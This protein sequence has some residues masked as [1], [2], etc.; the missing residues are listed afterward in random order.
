MRNVMCLRHLLILG[1][2]GSTLVACGLLPF[3]PSNKTHVLGHVYDTL[4]RPVPGARIDVVDGPQAGVSTTADARGGFEFV[5]T[6]SGAVRLRASRD[7][8]EP[9]TIAAEWLPSAS[10]QTIDLTLRTLGPALPLVPGSYTLTVTSD[11]S[12]AT[13][14]YRVPCEGFPADLR[15]RTYEASITPST[16][17][18]FVADLASPTMTKPPGVTCRLSAASP[19]VRGCFAF[20]VAGQFVGFEIQNS[21]GWDWI[22]EWPGFRYL[23]IQGTAPTSEPA[24]ATES[25]ITIPFF[26][27]FEYCQLK[28]A[29]GQPT[30]GQVPAEQVIEYRSCSSEHDTM[31]FTKH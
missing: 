25:S 17:E 30:C 23:M 1:V 10:L 29:L 2:L 6:A 3:G 16:N 4:S 8:F 15:R 24:T 13:S 18:Y 12:T 26:G 22:E 20:R 14:G 28:S 27:G 31:V 21:W 11:L 5:S 7:G 19:S 9:S